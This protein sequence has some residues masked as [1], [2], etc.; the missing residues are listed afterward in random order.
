MF[1]GLRRTAGISKEDFRENFGRE[2]WEVFADER[3]EFD[4]FVRGDFAED[5]ET[6]IRLTKAGMNISNR[7]MLLFV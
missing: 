1:T 6:G 7:I 2:L 3:A 5:D 4:T